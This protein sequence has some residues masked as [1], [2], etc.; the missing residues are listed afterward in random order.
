ME[1]Y[2][3]QPVSCEENDRLAQKLSR[4]LQAGTEALNKRLTEAAELKH[5]VSYVTVNTLIFFQQAEE[6]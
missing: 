1:E 3:L 5:T 6:F 2:E 4:W